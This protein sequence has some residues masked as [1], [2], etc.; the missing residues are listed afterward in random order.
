MGTERIMSNYHLHLLHASI[1]SRER[2]AAAW[3]EADW[4]EAVTLQAGVVDALRK[5][6]W[7]V[8]VDDSEADYG[9]TRWLLWVRDVEEAQAIVA[10]TPLGHWGLL[11]AKQLDVEDAPSTQA[12]LGRVREERGGDPEPSAADNLLAQL[13]A[14]IPR[15]DAL[16]RLNDPELGDAEQLLLACAVYC[17][18]DRAIKAGDTRRASAELRDSLLEKLLG[19]VQD[20]RHYDDAQARLAAPYTAGWPF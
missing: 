15:E 11:K 9:L 2:A 16:E 13:L 14:Q 6:G 12:W 1:V 20:T 8:A 10:G 19:A 7:I 5:L 18:M 3:E 4:I 17:A